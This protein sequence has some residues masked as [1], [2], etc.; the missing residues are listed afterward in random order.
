MFSGWTFFGI[1]TVDA[2]WW[3]WP[4]MRT[5]LSSVPSGKMMIQGVMSEPAKLPEHREL[6]WAAVPT[7]GNVQSLLRNP[8]ICPCFELTWYL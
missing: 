2:G 8:S 6:L 1:E 3:M 7:L 4:Q 5:F